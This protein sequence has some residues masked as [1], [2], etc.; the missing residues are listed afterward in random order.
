MKLFLLVSKNSAI[1]ISQSSTNGLP[2]FLFRSLYFLLFLLTLL[3]TSGSYAQTASRQ[4][5]A[6]RKTIHDRSDKI[7]K[8]LEIKDQAKY[9]AV[10]DLVMNQ[11]FDLNEVHDGHKKVITDIKKQGLPKEETN[12]AIE[13]QEEKKS[14]RLLQL[15]KAFIGHLKDNLADTQVDKIKNGMTYNVFHVTYTAYQDMIP[16]LTTAQKGKIYEWL[17]EAREKAM[18]EGSSDDKHKVFGKYK[19]RINN[20]LSTEGY[21]LKKEEEQ[22]RERLKTRRNEQKQN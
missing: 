9:T 2:S 14:G 21:D 4:D 19:G 11:Y 5:S 12:K 15:H 16:G 1:C 3:Y 13:A 8:S 22:W 17:I 6:Y 18:D 20:Y 10:L 7:V